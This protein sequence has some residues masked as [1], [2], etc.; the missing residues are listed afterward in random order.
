MTARWMMACFCSLSN[1]I[2][3]NT[4]AFEIATISGPMLSGFPVKFGGFALIFG[5]LSA[6]AEYLCVQCL[7][8][9]IVIAKSARL[10]RAAARAGD[11]VPAVWQRNSWT[12]RWM[13]PWRVM[14]ASSR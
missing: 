9:L 13:R 4:S 11:L 1:A 5:G 10:R 14:P 8:L 12:M 6:Q 7:Q 3:W 2:T